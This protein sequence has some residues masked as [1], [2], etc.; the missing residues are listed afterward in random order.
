[1]SKDDATLTT[2][3]S[4]AL[5]S[6]RGRKKKRQII[7]DDDDEDEPL[8]KSSKVSL[9]SAKYGTV[10]T[11]GTDTKLTTSSVRLKNVQSVQ[12]VKTSETENVTATF[13]SSTAT[14]TP[15]A[16]STAAAD[17]QSVND[18]VKSTPITE[19]PKLETA[20][21]PKPFR[22]NHIPAQIVSASAMATAKPTMYQR[23]VAFKSRSENLQ[24][25]ADCRRTH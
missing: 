25:G 16:T 20:P 12:E 5:K 14:T 10:S 21:P 13:I 23:R 17:S 9:T 19:P 4:S 6:K 7:F 24:S 8:K 15:A 18:P 2:G 1:M 3:V 11:N 22:P